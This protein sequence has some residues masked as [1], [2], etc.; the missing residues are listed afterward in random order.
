MPV[1]VTGIAVVES[2]P[3]LATVAPKDREP[4]P[5]EQFRVWNGVSQR[6]QL[7]AREQQRTPAAIGSR[8]PDA[9]LIALGIG[10]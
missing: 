8:Q 9:W 1:P 2:N 7:D 5:F 3:E 10:G 4:L 6:R